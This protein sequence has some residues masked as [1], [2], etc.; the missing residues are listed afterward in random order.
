MINIPEN[1]RINKMK[2]SIP[3]KK[4][5]SFAVGRMN[6]YDQLKSISK[7]SNKDKKKMIK[8]L[9][10]TILYKCIGQKH[11]ESTLRFNFNYPESDDWYSLDDIYCEINSN[12]FV[13]L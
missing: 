3:D 12:G 7:Y 8:W 10:E 1:V 6:K 13:Q 9:N 5:Y 11:P 2:I 4:I